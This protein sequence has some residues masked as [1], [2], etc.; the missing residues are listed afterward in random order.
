MY[1]IAIASFDNTNHTLELVKIKL[2]SM[3]LNTRPP[4]NSDN[5]LILDPVNRFGLQTPSFTNS[6]CQYLNVSVKTVK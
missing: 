5:N 2:S 3:N 1:H 6:C 4:G